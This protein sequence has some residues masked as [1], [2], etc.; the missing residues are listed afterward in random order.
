M[1]ARRGVD[2][3]EYIYML[4]ALRVLPPSMFLFPSGAFFGSSGA[5]TRQIHPCR[6]VSAFGGVR[7][8]SGARWVVLEHLDVE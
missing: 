8:T 3:G 2:G 7:V 6:G 5:Y 4:R 1:R